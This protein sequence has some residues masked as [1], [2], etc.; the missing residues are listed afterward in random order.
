MST[1]LGPPVEGKNFIGR[2]KILAKLLAIVQSGMHILLS[3]PRRVG[4][5]SIAKRLLFHLRNENWKGIYVSVEGAHDEVI[6][7]KRIIDELRKHSSLWA[8]IKTGVLETFKNSNI[9][10]EAFGVKLKYKTN[11]NEVMILLE[12]LGRAVQSIKSDFIVIIDELP[13]FLAH[14]ERQ[15]DGLSRVETV[16]NTLRSF[17]QIDDGHSY[18]RLHQKVWFFCGS[19]SLESFANQRNLAYT[20]NDVRSIKVGAYE[21]EEAI[22]YIQ[23]I[24]IREGYHIDEDTQQYII[25]KIEWPI[26][27]YLGI[28][29]E[30]AMDKSPNRTIE[31]HHI[32]DGYEEALKTHKKDFD[33]WI[34]RLQLHIKNYEVYLEILK[35]IATHQNATLPLIKAKI[36]STEWSNISQYLKSY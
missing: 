11:S 13:V 9:D 27:Y 25:S 34:Q 20:I 10:I 21:P 4:K 28:I 31:Q 26:P 7:A 8:H 22:A 36:M 16:L 29:L 30:A 18:E 2:K 33:Q 19:I 15:E 12:T 6:F 1:Y 32:D 24:S 17:R 14:L 35:I 5:T 3:A 23:T